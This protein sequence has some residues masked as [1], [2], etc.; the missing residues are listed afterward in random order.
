[1]ADNKEYSV[2]PGLE[3]GN[4]TLEYLKKKK[5]EDIKANLSDDKFQQLT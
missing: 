5:I 4:N 2:N 1:M 3:W